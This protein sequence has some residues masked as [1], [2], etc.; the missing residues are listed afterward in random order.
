MY[1]STFFAIDLSLI[2][3]MKGRDYGRQLAIVNN[4]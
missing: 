1:L 2:I 3:L 4:Q